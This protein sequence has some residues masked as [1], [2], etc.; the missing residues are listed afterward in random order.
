LLVRDARGGAL[1]AVRHTFTVP[2]ADGLRTSTPILTDAVPGEAGR[3]L[4]VPLAR[5]H[6]A[7]GSKLFYVF[8]VYGASGPGEVKISYAVGRGGQTLAEAA[9][10]AAACAGRA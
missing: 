7:S 1:G 8:D 4:P 6:F 3:E 10:R 2:P 5:R 9:P